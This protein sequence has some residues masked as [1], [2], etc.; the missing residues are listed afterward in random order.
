MGEYGVRV[1][2]SARG[3]RVAGA[4]SC[5]A[6]FECSARR[7]PGPD[8]EARGVGRGLRDGERRGGGTARRIPAASA[9]VRGL[10]GG[11]GGRMAANAL[12]REET[13]R[14]QVEDPE[15]GWVL[16]LRPRGMIDIA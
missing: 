5:D 8:D 3:L 16:P 2:L 9:P 13:D 14:G 1:A 4:S 6:G 15:I 10:L 12:R 11:C 7:L